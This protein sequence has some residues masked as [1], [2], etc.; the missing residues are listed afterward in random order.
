MRQLMLAKS[1]L[2]RRRALDLNSFPGAVLVF[3]LRLLTSPRRTLIRRN[4]LALPL[5]VLMSS[6]APLHQPLSSPQRS[7]SSAPTS[8]YSPHAHVLGRAAE[9]SCPP[10]DAQQPTPLAS[11][12]ARVLQRAAACHRRSS[13]TSPRD[14]SEQHLRTQLPLSAALGCCR[15]RCFP[16]P[17]TEWNYPP[18]RTR[19]PLTCPRSS[20]AT[21]TS[22]SLRLLMSFRPSRSSETNPSWR[23]PWPQQGF[24]RLDDMANHVT[25]G[26]YTSTIFSRSS[27]RPRSERSTPSWC[28]HTSTPSRSHS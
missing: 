15:C 17:L 27:S 13:T 4:R 24:S 14:P 10:P 19:S 28:P 20:S 26:S 5:L 9:P 21:A 3:L 23:L 18:R 1:F 7:P 22:T 2:R 12:H 6:G 16:R 25:Q 8:P 11:S